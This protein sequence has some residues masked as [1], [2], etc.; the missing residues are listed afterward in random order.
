MSKTY[1]KN[2][3]NFTP[4]KV[5][6]FPLFLVLCRFSLKLLDKK[7]EGALK[8][9]HIIE[10]NAIVNNPETAKIIDKLTDVQEKFGV[11]KL[12]ATALSM[13]Q[14]ENM[15]KKEDISG[16]LQKCLNIQ[17]QISTKIGEKSKMAERQVIC[18]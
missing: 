3:L 12:N 5:C 15:C 6:K 1:Y 7:L 8:R 17:S 2:A 4:V 11:D 18:L 16:Q 14:V 9:L 13:V 10:D